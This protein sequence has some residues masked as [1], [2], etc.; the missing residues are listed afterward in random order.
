M[1]RS[2]YSC[3]QGYSVK[4]LTTSLSLEKDESPVLGKKSRGKGQTKG[5]AQGHAQSVAEWGIGFKL[6]NLHFLELIFKLLHFPF[7]CRFCY[8]EFVVVFYSHLCVF[9]C[10]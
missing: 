7:M 9:C 1:P 3:Q 8:T 6:F 2:W 5:L 4:I 10:S